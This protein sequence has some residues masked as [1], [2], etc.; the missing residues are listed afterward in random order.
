M[1]SKRFI[2][3]SL[4]LTLVL[5]ILVAG[6]QVAVDPLFQYH[7]PWFGMKPVMTGERY[8]NAGVAKSF[9]YKNVIMGNS[10]AQNF[11]VSDI[12][13]AL[14][15]KTVKLTA[16]GSH[17]LD[18]TYTLDVLS[19]KNKS[20]TNIVMNMDPYIFN[21]S[22]NELKHEL[23][24]YLYD[25]NYLNDGN[26]LFN[27]SI[28]Q[29]Y[30]YRAVMNNLTHNIPDYDTFMLWDDDFEYGKDFVLSHYNR[31]EVST[32]AYDIDD[33]EKYCDNISKNLSL[34]LPYFEEMSDTEFVFFLSPFSMLYWDRE[35][36]ENGLEKQKAG[37]LK[38]CE[39]LSAYDNVTLYLWTD[40]E[41]LG[42]MGDLNNYCDEAHYCPDVCEMMAERIGDKEGIITKE[43]YKEEINKLF[44]YVE[45]YDYDSLFV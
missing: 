25:N 6:V 28:L 4:C 30:T 37:Y 34:L 7:T 8:Q 44:D 1:N 22:Y 43:T 13:E 2:R 16:S 21:G 15:G 31:P 40:D 10:L 9:E 41:M 17:P 14:G 42:V 20:P 45:N 38:T 23:P 29:K 24:T 33:I 19:K 35:T 12:G 5:L 39:I 11:K 3:L 32:G 26:Y 18:W 36:R 27:F